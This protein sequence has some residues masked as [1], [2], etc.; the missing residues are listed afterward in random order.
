M[1]AEH[2]AR[3]EGVV[4]ARWIDPSV[5]KPQGKKIRVT[6]SRGAVPTKDER[7][8]DRLSMM[9]RLTKAPR[10]LGIGCGRCRTRRIV[11]KR[12]ERHR[13]S[14]LSLKR[15]GASR[16]VEQEGA[17]SVLPRRLCPIELGRGEGVE[18]WPSK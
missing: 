9:N 4:E 15:G 17:R 3:G 1:I 7:K 13:S 14:D 5:G 2:D 8:T 6:N 10:K 11:P 12:E 18:Q 16:V